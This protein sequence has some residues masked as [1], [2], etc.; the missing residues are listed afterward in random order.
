MGRA[1]A[2]IDISDGLLADA[3]H[4]A[5][6]SGV[7]ITIESEMLPLSVALKSHHNP[8]QALEWALGGGDDYELCFTLPADIS[9]PPGCTRIGQV[10]EGEGVHCD[11]D[12]DI[13][14][15]YRHF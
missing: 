6:S 2:A 7:K 12:I 9:A 10:S 13:V 3:G 8:R 15:G 1:T 5:A 14:S 4:I 11:V